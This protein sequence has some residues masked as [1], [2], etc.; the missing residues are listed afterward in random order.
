MQERG[1]ENVKVQLDFENRNRF[2]KFGSLHNAHSMPKLNFR[3]WN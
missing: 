2:S 3:N 1:K